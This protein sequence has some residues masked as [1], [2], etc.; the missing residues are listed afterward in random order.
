MAA[1]DKRGQ[2]SHRL[3]VF[4]GYDIQGKFDLFT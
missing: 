3:T 4:C 1:I 2:N